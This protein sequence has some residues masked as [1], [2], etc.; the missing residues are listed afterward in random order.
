MT[1]DKRGVLQCPRAQNGPLWHRRGRSFT[2]LASSRGETA[3]RGSGTH[4]A[5]TL[6]TVS[7]APRENSVRRVAYAGPI[8]KA[9]YIGDI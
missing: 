1:V 6:S 9:L 3:S 4:A 5:A 2:S 7:G 8:A